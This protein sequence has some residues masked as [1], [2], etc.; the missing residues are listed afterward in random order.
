MVRED[1]R[2]FK[3]VVVFALM[4]F[5]LILSAGA[6]LAEDIYVSLPEEDF[7]LTEGMQV[8]TNVPDF[9]VDVDTVSVTDINWY[10]RN[11]KQYELVEPGSCF[12]K[13][14][15]HVE[16]TF[17]DPYDFLPEDDTNTIRVNGQC[18]YETWKHVT[19]DGTEKTYASPNFNIM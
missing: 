11:G 12:H 8:P 18:G 19:T 16:L 10:F 7:A 14:S 9:E 15:W 4:V 5:S 3:A 13:G 2:F 6:V 1:K 17:D